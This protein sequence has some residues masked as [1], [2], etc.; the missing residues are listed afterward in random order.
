MIELLIT[1][2]PLLI[3]IAYLRWRKREIS[4]Y[5]VHRAVFIWMIL[6]F[7]LI[8]TIEY[9]HPDSGNA[10]IPF[11][12]VPVVAEEGGTVT[13]IYVVAGQHVD[14][15]DILFT[16]DD[17]NE[18]A[19]VQE[20]KARVSEV[21]AQVT[22]VQSQ[23]PSAQDEVAAAQADLA[24][25]QLTLSNLERLGQENSP[26]Y[27][28]DNYL[29]AKDRFDSATAKVHQTEQAV[30]SLQIQ[31]DDV[32][33]AQLAAA[34]ASLES[35][36][37]DLD[38]T[39]ITSEVAGRIDQLTLNVGD[40]AGRFAMTPAMVIVPDITE[41]NPLE[42]VGGFSQTNQ[43][44]L[45]VGMPAE[46]ACKPN[47]NNAMTDAVFPARITR[48]Q[49]SIATG[50]VG[51]SG[52]L[53]Q[54][55]QRPGTGDLVVYASLVYPEHEKMLVEGS[56]CILQ[57]YTT[58]IGGSMQGTF[59]GDLIEAWAIEKALIMR[60]KVWLMLFVGTGLAGG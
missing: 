20:A 34:K 60:M 14:P 16:V 18:R 59:F 27:A 13:E 35:A 56:R 58:H 43:A 1:C 26:A 12:V 6:F 55:S 51:P 3:R 53:L 25:A 24:S 10:L 52:T 57:V 19:R 47:I 7:M 29:R 30:V 42:I 11:R 48:I 15:G 54:P 8:F 23:I 5:N 45:H 9:Y 36:Q 17:V 32:L 49:S 44:V 22:E 4:V 40:R 21:N 31:I 46:V 37:A 28:E 39:R 38:K 2:F 41:A 33:P 50:Q